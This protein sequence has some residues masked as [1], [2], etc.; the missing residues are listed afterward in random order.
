MSIP[1][2]GSG[3]GSKRDLG[4]GIANPGIDVKSW[5]LG[6]RI[7][8][9]SRPVPVPT[10][11]QYGPNHTGIKSLGEKSME[12]SARALEPRSTLLRC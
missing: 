1:G 12:K 10:P 3:T 7:G 8:R 11:G 4:P 9:D 6:L 2:I 5:I